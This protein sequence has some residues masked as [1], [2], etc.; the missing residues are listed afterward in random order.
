L[1]FFFIGSIILAR[2][3]VKPPSL[4]RRT[5]KTQNK[6]DSTN[7]SIAS[8]DSD[9]YEIALREQN[10]KSFLKRA[11]VFFAKFFP[12]FWILFIVSLALHWIISLSMF[13][14]LICIVYYLAKP[15]VFRRY[16]AEEGSNVPIRKGEYAEKG[17]TQG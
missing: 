14:C 8:I 7:P 17:I 12:Y 11:S 9:E 4:S 3:L 5:F 10:D 13:L 16:A 6:R 2:T 15:M 1:S